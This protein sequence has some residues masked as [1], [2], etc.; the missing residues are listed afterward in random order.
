MWRPSAIAFDIYTF[1]YLKWSNHMN[2]ICKQVEKNINEL[3]EEQ[4]GW[5]A[6]A[7]DEQLENARN[8]KLEL[9][10]DIAVPREWISDIK[11]KDVLCL[12]GA[13]G[14]QTPLLS[15]AG[16]SV[17]VIDISEKM[18][19]KDYMVA[20]ANNLDIRIEHGN[21]CDLSRFADGSFDYVINPPSLFYV[22]DVMPVFKECYRVLRKGGI[23]ILG[24]PNPIAYICDYVEDENGGYY[25]AVNR[26]PYRST[27]FA[28][29]KGWVEYGHT[30][31]DY[32]GGLI[33]CGFVITGYV[34]HQNE[35]IT[36]LPFITKADKQ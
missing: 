27:D 1:I 6:C 19:E 29:Q 33:A 20:K 25:K 35:D 36:D 30:M 8:G 21:M 24:A 17:T 12:A 5:S 23:L 3:V 13:G 15:C 34:E 7:T 16:A 31:G 26:M 28:D 14:L 9:N 22:P 32:I 18:L 4:V 10:L 2:D 11:G